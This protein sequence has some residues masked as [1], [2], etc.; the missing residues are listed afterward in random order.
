LNPTTPICTVCNSQNLVELFDAPDFWVSKEKFTIVKCADCGFAYTKNAPD[1]ANIGKY[2]QHADYV[3]HT[4][5]QQGLFFKIYH[6]V[7]E[8]MLGKKRQMIEKHIVKGN[9]LDIGAGTGYFANHMQQNQW[10]VNGV[11]PDTGAAN[12]AQQKF[13]IKLNNSLE[14]VVNKGNTYQAISMWHVLEHV[15]ELDEYFNH[16]KK[17][18]AQNGKLFI[19]V[20]NHTSFDGKF[21]KQN[22]AAWDVPK[23]LWH[24]S[25]KSMQI[26]AEK[27]GFVVEQK[28]TLPFDSF[29]ISIMSEK[30]KGSSKL[31][32]IRA[33]FVGFISFVKA[34]F[35]V[36]KASSVVYVISPTPTFNENK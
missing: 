7:R 20:P 35:N 5:T 6:F 28:Y 17:L 8:T 33:A 29:Y 26:L 21:Y 34:L 1:A 31:T 4:D 13:N 30:I 3:S 9:L 11:E 23:H 22:W 18:L 2:Y 27:N 12:I 14:D 36:E 16:F 15:H 10:N 32:I 24:F 19:A 25:P